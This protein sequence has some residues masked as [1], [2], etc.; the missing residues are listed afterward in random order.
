MFQII[1]SSEESQPMTWRPWQR[2]SLSSH[3]NCAIEVHVRDQGVLASTVQSARRQDP[4]DPQS[5]EL[6][7][8]QNNSVSR[9]SMRKQAGEPS[10]SRFR[11]KAPRLWLT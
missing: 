3:C 6:L 8:R 11:R 1:T 7:A 10:L 9:S 4:A 5:S 2:H